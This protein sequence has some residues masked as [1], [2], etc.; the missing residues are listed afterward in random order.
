VRLKAGG[1]HRNVSQSPRPEAVSKVAQSVPSIGDCLIKKDHF[2]W[3]LQ[4]A[5][6]KAPQRNITP[7]TAANQAGGPWSGGLLK[8]LI[9]PTQ[10]ATPMPRQVN[11]RIYFHTIIAASKALFT[12]PRR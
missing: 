3:S 10:S 9:A 6:A 5:S 2:Y 7:N 1:E 8:M 12:C 4:R 11:R